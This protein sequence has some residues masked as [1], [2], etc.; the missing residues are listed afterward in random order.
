MR[1]HQLAVL[2]RY[3]IG[4]G[5]SRGDSVRRVARDLGRSPST[6]SRE[7]GPNADTRVE[8]ED[9]LQRGRRPLRERHNCETSSPRSVPPGH[10]ADGAVDRLVAHVG[11]M[12]QM[13]ACGPTS[14]GSATGD[15]L[16]RQAGAQ[17][18][19]HMQPPRG[20]QIGSELTLSKPGL[21]TSALGAQ[22]AKE[23]D[24][25]RSAIVGFSPGDLMA[26]RGAMAAKARGDRG[27]TD[28]EAHV[29]LND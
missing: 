10:G 16:G 6:I 28:T 3:P 7:L 2:G 18:L 20:V 29:D 26:D 21:A 15:N 13:R 1:H 27:W 14:A 4:R 9:C 8:R 22:I 17:T 25:G 5:K 12:I 24:V 11:R 19:A 23:G